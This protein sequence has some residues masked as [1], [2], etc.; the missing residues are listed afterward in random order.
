M[1]KW[2][3]R[4]KWETIWAKSCSM[5]VGNIFYGVGKTTGVAVVQVDKR[6]NK[7]RSYLSAAGSKSNID[8]AELLVMNSELAPILDYHKILY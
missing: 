6:K 8:V 3:K 7:Y 2:M 5:S 1:V 4:N